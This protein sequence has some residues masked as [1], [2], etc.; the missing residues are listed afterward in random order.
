MGKKFEM[1]TANEE[2]EKKTGTSGK[3][4]ALIAVV[5]LVLILSFPKVF[6][7]LGIAAVAGGLILGTYRV[8]KRKE[9]EEH[10]GNR[11]AEA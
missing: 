8:M 3:Q 2:K 11:K 5:Y 4:T 7:V 10:D 1:V 6:L 9:P